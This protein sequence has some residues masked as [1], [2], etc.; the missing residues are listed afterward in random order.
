MPRAGFACQTNG[1]TEELID[2]LT[3]REEGVLDLL[4]RGL[5]NA[6][7]ADELGISENTAKDHVSNI[8]RKLG[9]SSRDEAAY[10]PQKAPWWARAPLIAP[11]SLFLRHFARRLPGSPSLA[12]NVLAGAALILVVVGL[13]LLALLLLRTSGGEEPATTVLVIEEEGRWRSLLS[14]IPDT[15][16]SRRE[17]VMS[18]HAQ[19]REVYDIDQPTLDAGEDELFEYRREQVFA[20]PDFSPAEVLSL[21]NGPPLVDLRTELGFSFGDVD[22]DV[23]SQSRPVPYQIVRGRLSEER[24][25]AALRTDPSFSDILEEASYNGVNYFHW[26]YEGLNE[27]RISTVRRLG[28]GHQL[29]IIGDTLLWTR[30]F[31]DMEEMIDSW[32]GNLP[33]LGDSEDYQLLA[34]ALDEMGTY[35][36]LFSSDTSGLSVAAWEARVSATPEQAASELA[37]LPFVAFATGSG[38]DAEGEFISVALLHD[39]ADSAAENAVRLERRIESAF[40]VFF[41]GRGTEPPP[42]WSD[43]ISDAQI[44]VEE[45]LVIA[46]LYGEADRTT[47]FLALAFDSLLIHE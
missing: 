15:E 43:V 10:W 17:I 46:K 33:S 21:A 28:E 39:D 40:Q 23:S 18:D 29:A 30:R 45:R 42:L 22:L 20:R 19:I 1:M 27:N 13:Y 16:A 7:L 14:L 36:A 6:Q 32:L 44:E 25:E 4:R 9:A 41:N 3:P 47:S 24:V 31:A 35:S 26:G 12:T 38:L 2:P 8:L 34:D 5:T 11:L 37:L